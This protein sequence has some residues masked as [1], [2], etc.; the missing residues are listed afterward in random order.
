MSMKKKNGGRPSKYYT[1]VQPRLSEVQDWYRNGATDDI[2]AEKL[3]IAQSSLYEYKKTYPEFSESIKT[4]DEVDALVENALLR[5][6]LSGNIV[7][8]LFWLKNRRQK[9]WKDK[10]GEGIDDKESQSSKLDKII[11]NIKRDVE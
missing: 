8:Q 6:A 10:I 9:N 5:N 11:E 3:G 4:K 2:V 1:H 7:A